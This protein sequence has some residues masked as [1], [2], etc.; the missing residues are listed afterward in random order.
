[1]Q[2]DC[3]VT[4]LENASA[5]IIARFDLLSKVKEEQDPQNAKHCASKIRT[6]EGMEDGFRDRQ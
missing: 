1:M 4:Q 5:A 2:I 6:E 3:N